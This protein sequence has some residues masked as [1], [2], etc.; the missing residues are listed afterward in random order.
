MLI[1]VLCYLRFLLYWRSFCKESEIEI[2]YSIN[3]FLKLLF[4]CIQ[5]IAKWL[6]NWYIYIYIYTYIYIYIYAN[7]TQSG[8][9]MS[10]HTKLR[11]CFSDPLGWTKFVRLEKTV[12]WSKRLKPGRTCLNWKGAIEMNTKIG[13]ST[14]FRAEAE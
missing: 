8:L 2:F 13:E 11:E 14:T 10:F 9:R 1:F 12:D 6:S 5:H 7:K 3:V 4:I